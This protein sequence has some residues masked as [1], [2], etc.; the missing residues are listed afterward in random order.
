MFGYMVCSATRSMQPLPA[1]L[2]SPLPCLVTWFV[3]RHARCSR[4]RPVL[5]S[6]LPC[7]VTWF[8]QRHAP[9]AATGLSSFRPCHVWLHGL[10]SDTLHAA[11]SGLS[12][13]STAMFGYMVCSATRSK[14]R[15]PAFFVSPLPCLVTSFVQRHAPC[16]G[17]RPFLFSPLL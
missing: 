1:F 6:P 4:Y 14:Q 7:L 11:A 9:S 10:F 2:V 5:V 12:S 8:V 16:S 17:Y 3:Q 13:F 15:L